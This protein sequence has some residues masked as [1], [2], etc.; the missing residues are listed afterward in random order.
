MQDGGIRRK[1][2]VAAAA[3]AAAVVPARG[4]AAAWPLA[5]ARAAR[6]ACGLPLTMRDLREGRLSLAEL[7]DMPPERGLIALLEGPGEALGLLALSPEVLAGIVERQ[8]LG[9]VLRQTAMPRRPTRTDAAMVAGLIDAALAGLDQALSADTDKVWASGFRYASFL[10]EARPLALLLEDAAHVVLTAEADLD[11][12]AKSGLVLLAL[13]AEGRG[14]PPLRRAA[15]A[16]QGVQAAFRRALTDRVEP[17]EAVLT[18]VIARLQMPLET[19]LALAPG[20]LLALAPAAVDRVDLDGADGLRVAGGRLGQN[21]GM[22]A[23]RLAETEPAARLAA[24]P[25]PE[26]APALRAV[27]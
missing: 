10:E 9:R 16:D 5:L 4:A 1:V 13:P 21:R 19:V 27:G 15:G 12:G 8:T 18:A 26:A 7:L 11:T 2:A 25:T 3:Q 22:R 24:Q 20:A 23:I 17:A 14:A 6:D